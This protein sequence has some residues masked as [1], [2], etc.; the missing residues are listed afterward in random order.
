MHAMSRTFPPRIAD[1]IM[2]RDQHR[3]VMCG[4]KKGLTIHA[5]TRDPKHGGAAA[6]IV[7][8]KGYGSQMCKEWC[9]EN[10]ELAIADGYMVE[11]GANPADQPIMHQLKGHVTL[12]D[13]GT[14]F[15]YQ[16]GQK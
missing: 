6:G 10:P 7:L 13:R 9:D 2:L 15:R 5:R 4:G 8:C 3:C 14:F 11:D 16:G 1:L 12:S